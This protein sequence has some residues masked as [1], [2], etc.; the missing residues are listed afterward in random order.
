MKCVV[1][2]CIA[3]IPIC[4]V[5]SFPVVFVCLFCCPLYRSSAYG[6]VRPPLSGSTT[7]S[8]S[9]SVHIWYRIVSY[10]CYEMS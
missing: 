9:S 6:A 1:F 5:L 8:S 3:D 2:Y 7:T 4:N 10:C